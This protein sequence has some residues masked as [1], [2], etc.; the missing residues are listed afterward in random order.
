MLQP[1]N[2]TAGKLFDL[3]RSLADFFETNSVKQFEE[4]TAKCNLWRIMKISFLLVLFVKTTLA[5]CFTW[6][7]FKMR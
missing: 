7:S 5:V 2:E 1:P 4:E 3:Q 6:L